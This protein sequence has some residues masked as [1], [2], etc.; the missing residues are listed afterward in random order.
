M[1]IEEI[2]RKIREVAEPV[3]EQH[4][5]FFV[6]CQ[7]RNERG[8]RVVQLFVDTDAGITIDQCA[9]VSRAL[10][11]ELDAYPLFDTSFH[12]EVSSPGIDRPLKLL[13]QYQK[14]VGRKF[15]VKY[16]TG[17]EPLT[18]SA[19]LVSVT[20]DRLT[21]QPASGEELSLP[22]STIIESKEELPW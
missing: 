19:I 1:S 2:R 15:T 22:F 17:P 6:D 11:A 4:K 10:S 5:A 8:T 13:R 7:I 18:V 16:K 20:D 14:N 9:E 12:L 3:L 21:F